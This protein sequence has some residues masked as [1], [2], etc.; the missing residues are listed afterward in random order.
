MNNLKVGKGGLPPLALSGFK[1]GGG[2]P[3][4]PTLRLSIMNLTAMD[5][6]VTNMQKRLCLSN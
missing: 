2:K 1:L 6:M 3:P 4:F 5:H